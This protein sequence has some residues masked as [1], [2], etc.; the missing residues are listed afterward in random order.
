MYRPVHGLDTSST[1]PFT[2]RIRVIYAYLGT[3]KG[4]QS[5]PIWVKTDNL[6]D[7]LD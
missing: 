5:D 6:T 3:F 7:R 2:S 4:T 1:P